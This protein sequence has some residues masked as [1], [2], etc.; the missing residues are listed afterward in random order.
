[1]DNRFS[2]LD[3]FCKYI[4]G[5]IVTSV[6]FGISMLDVVVARTQVVLH[7]CRELSSSYF[8]LLNHYVIQGYNSQDLPYLAFCGPA[9]VVIFTMKLADM[10]TSVLLANF[11]K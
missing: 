4:L 7:S 9:P 3:L 10:S 8:R 5:T 1:M 2:V 11:F 6:L